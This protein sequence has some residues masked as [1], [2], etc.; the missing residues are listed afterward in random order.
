MIVGKSQI[1][2]THAARSIRA[3]ACSRR[4]SWYGFRSASGRASSV[5]FWSS[6]ERAGMGVGVSVGGG[7]CEWCE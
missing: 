6:C 2:R 4:E 7:E 3:D 5:E 1:D